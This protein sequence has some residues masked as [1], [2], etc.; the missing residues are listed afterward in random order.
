[1]KL[2]KNFSLEEFV[3]K[4]YIDWYG[5][6]VSMGFI[7]KRIVQVVQFFRNRYNKPI[8]I[9][10]E[11]GGLT[12][13]ESGVR[14]FNTQ[15]GAMMSQHKFGRAADMKWIGMDADEVRADIINNYEKFVSKG[16]TTVEK[17][18]DTWIHV[19]CRYTKDNLIR[20][21]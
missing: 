3:P 10:G 21:V 5:T 6:T 16:L 13:T 7:D 18:T 4:K 14:S 17:N 1:M 12:F 8:V 20:F 15:T 2:T 9:N 19:D 11:F